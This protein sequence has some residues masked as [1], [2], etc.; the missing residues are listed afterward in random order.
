MYLLSAYQ[1]SAFSQEALY[2]QYKGHPSATRLKGPKR[3]ATWEQFLNWVDPC[4]SIGRYLLMFTEWM[5]EQMNEY[6]LK[7]VRYQVTQNYSPN[8][9]GI[10]RIKINLA[11][12]G[13]SFLP[14]S[15]N[16]LEPPVPQ[17]SM[18][19]LDFHLRNAN[20]WSLACR[21]FILIQWCY[22]K[23]LMSC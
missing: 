23:F 6:V 13:V 7:P 2:S 11:N 15:Y 21:S 4:F 10:Q 14:W 20:W 18:P 8:T 3:L 12:I 22:Q 17:D 1:R 19:L 16:K 9:S 5:N